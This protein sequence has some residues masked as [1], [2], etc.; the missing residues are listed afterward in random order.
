MEDDDFCNK[1]ITVGKKYRSDYLNYKRFVDC[2][3]YSED[4]DMSFVARHYDNIVKYWR[5]GE[6]FNELVGEIDK[7]EI[8]KF[9]NDF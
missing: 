1:L 5:N 6:N 7:E 8:K 3:E 2:P 4:F 9:R